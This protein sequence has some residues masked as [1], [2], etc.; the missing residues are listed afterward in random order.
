[1]MRYATLLVCLL[2]GPALA[3]MYKWT[4]E[5][6]KTHYSDQPPPGTTKSETIK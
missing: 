5:N 3:D 6:G 4:D 2:A 1:M